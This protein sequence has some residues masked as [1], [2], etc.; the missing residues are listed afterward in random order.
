MKLHELKPGGGSRHRPKR[1]GRG[2]GSGHGKTSCRG[3]NGQGQRS[4]ESLGRGF[5]GGQM[6]LYRRMPKKKGFGMFKG[7]AHA[8]INVG[9]L[10]DL[11]PGTTVTFELLH[12]QGLVGDRGWGL[13]VL[14]EGD[15]SVA[16]HVQANHFTAGAR[17]KIQAAGGTATVIKD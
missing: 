8:V 1:V 16:L 17:A 6:P 9:D 3:Y 5:E 14:G 10:S 11:K 15:L 7:K 2:H 13:R 4:G 12:E